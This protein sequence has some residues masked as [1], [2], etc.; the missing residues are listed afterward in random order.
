MA[1]GD[2]S[3]HPPSPSQTRTASSSQRLGFST[4]RPTLTATSRLGFSGSSSIN[5]STSTSSNT[6][7][8]ASSISTCRFIKATRC[9][10]WAQESTTTTTLTAA[11][12]TTTITTTAPAVPATPSTITSAAVHQWPKP[13]H[14]LLSG[15]VLQMTQLKTCRWRLGG[16]PH[17]PCHFP[18]PRTSTNCRCLLLTTRGLSARPPSCC[19]SKKW[20]WTVPSGTSAS[21]SLYRRHTTDRIR[22]AFVRVE[23]EE[24][25]GEPVLQFG[26]SSQNFQ[27]L[28]LAQT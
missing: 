28:S 6:S 26:Q 25:A 14:L 8:S 12:T 15:L 21:P 10:R 13:H 22:S 4:T 1:I 7:T 18:R 24:A 11:T 20:A 17:W 16:Q 27:M 23:P 5:T 3:S 19:H 2:C 9:T